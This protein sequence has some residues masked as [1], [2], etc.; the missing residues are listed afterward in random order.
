[1][2][3]RL[4]LLAFS[5]A[6]AL[7][8][9]TVDDA[10]AH[11]NR[12][13]AL[14]HGGDARAAAAEFSEAIRIRPEW[15]V[16]HYGLG[17]ADHDLG[18]DAV[19]KPELRR[20]IELEPGNMAVRK[21]LAAILLN[22]GDANGAIEQYR[23][24]PGA[25]VRLPLGRAYLQAGHPDQAI[26]QIRKYVTAKPGDSEA[27]YYLGVALGQEGQL[28]AALAEFRRAIAL[29]PGFGP[30]HQE[31][32]VALRR[33]GN[34][35][36]A[37][38]EFRAAARL[39]PH[40]PIALL[41]LGVALKKAGDLGG[42]IAALRQAL[43][44][45]P[46]LERAKYALSIALRQQGQLAEAEGGM[47]DVAQLHRSRAQM[48]ES[49]KLIL[50]GVELFKRQQWKEAL[51]MFQEA[52]AISP[53]MPECYYYAGRASEKLGD[54]D[55]AL[56]EYGKALA[57]RPDY[58]EAHMS[59]GVLYARRNDTEQALDHLRQAVLGNPDLADAHYNLALVLAGAGKP[60]EAERELMDAIAIAPGN[61]D[62]RVLLGNV[63]AQQ[64]L[65]ARA[66]EAYNN[67][68]L[69]WLKAGRLSEAKT[70]FEEAL[71]QKP[72]DTAARNNL[73]LVLAK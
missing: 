52:A 55:R 35:A 45:K 58:P 21:Y 22:E 13:L 23:A 63:L 4:A 40:N 68:G 46:D 28:D 30:A 11:Y 47:R 71:R 37:L 62:A 69:L 3:G 44:F 67:L 6:L 54:G 2:S 59:L 48:A 26:E 20:A 34:D 36:G 25:D 64:G 41:D 39:M 29:Q 16:A 18:N 9:S 42:A 15:A 31:L 38:V 53:K 19:A 43:Q 56:D 66:A 49:K 10:A 70:A 60:V 72:D 33:A 50:D 14:K 57:L 12:A 5:A 1:M 24:I 27:R 7:G 73:V 51:D 8:G 61:L 17:A 32:G 65:P